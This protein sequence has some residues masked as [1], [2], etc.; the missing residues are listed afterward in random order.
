MILD[1]V[2]ERHSVR[3]Y[4]NKDIDTEI[5]LNIVKCGQNYPSRGNLQPLK[6]I[7][8]T[9]KKIRDKVADTIL[10]GSKNSNFSVFKNNEYVPS[11][12]IVVCVDKKIMSSGYEYEVGA[13]IEAILLSA[14]ER[15]INSLWVKSF[16]KKVLREILNTDDNIILDSLICLGYSDQ[17]NRRITLKDS[18][19]VIVDDD[20]NMITP[21]RKIEEVLFENEYNK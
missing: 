2:N 14:T 8:I 21:K 19:K 1:L 12:Y 10:W 18:V 3:K 4:N 13:S 5:L 15:K 16:D 17:E 7:L 6:Y 20:L 11:N 9:D